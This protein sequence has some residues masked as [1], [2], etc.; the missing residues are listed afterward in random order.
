MVTV[1]VD[2]SLADPALDILGDEGTVNMDQR[3]AQWRNEGWGGR[4]AQRV[5]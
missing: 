3:T 2:E 1:R 4:F 5:P